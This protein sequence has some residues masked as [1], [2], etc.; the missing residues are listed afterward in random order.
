MRIAAKGA[1]EWGEWE[2]GR[3]R[4]RVRGRE[5]GRE[6]MWYKEGDEERRNTAGAKVRM[7]LAVDCMASWGHCAGWIGNNV[8]NVRR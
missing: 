3:D 1:G 8:S 5:R 4:R 2:R 6:E 7:D